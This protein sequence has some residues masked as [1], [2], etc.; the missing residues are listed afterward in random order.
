MGSTGRSSWSTSLWGVFVQTFP[1]GHEP[2][3]SHAPVPGMKASS[4]ARRALKAWEEE[5]RIR[6][7]TWTGYK[8]PE[9]SLPT[10][11]MLLASPVERG[12]SWAGCSHTPVACRVTFFSL[13]PAARG[14]H[15]FHLRPTP[16]TKR[17]AAPCKMPRWFCYTRGHS[18]GL[19]ELSM[20]FLQSQNAINNRYS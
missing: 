15:P 16:W 4:V 10:R 19:G 12:H 9:M 20:V 17:T 18:G 8:G 3:A 1:E 14:G 5:K 7:F 13:L 11:K 2:C 6:C